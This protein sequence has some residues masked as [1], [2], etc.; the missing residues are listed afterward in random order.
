M[1]MSIVE[2]RMESLKMALELNNSLNSLDDIIL[3]ADKIY[4]YLR[5]TELTEAPI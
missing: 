1:T 2:I 3:K 5:A 4:Q